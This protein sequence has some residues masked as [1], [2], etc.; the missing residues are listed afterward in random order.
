MSSDG[1]E[2]MHKNAF[3]SRDN[4]VEIHQ[5]S[6]FKLGACSLRKLF[7]LTVRVVAAQ[8]IVVVSEKGTFAVAIFDLM[9]TVS[10]RAIC[11]FCITVLHWQPASV[12]TLE[13]PGV[14]VWN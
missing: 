2:A 7:Y 10:I 6:V 3:N 13:S 14:C 11:I 9:H 12:M 8:F 1:R 4:F 5:S